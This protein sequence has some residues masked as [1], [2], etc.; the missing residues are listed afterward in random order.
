MALAS[1]TVIQLWPPKKSMPVFR[2]AL[3]LTSLM[4]YL[5]KQLLLAL[6]IIPT[7]SIR[8]L[9]LISVHF[10]TGSSYFVLNRWFL[11]ILYLTIDFFR[12]RFHFMVSFDFVLDNV[13]F[14]LY[15]L[16][17]SMS[18]EIKW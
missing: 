11:S 15:V 9:T 3:Q 2:R 14:R 4:S 17:D 7:M 8:V 16:V 5:P 10:I 6:L 12:F 1:I 18:I 13:I